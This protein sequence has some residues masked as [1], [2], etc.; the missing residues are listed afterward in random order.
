MHVEKW[1]CLFLFTQIAKNLAN[2]GGQLQINPRA[3]LR[4]Y[5]RP[6]IKTPG[7]NNRRLQTLH[8]SRNNFLCLVIVYCVRVFDRL[9]GS[10]D[11][12]FEKVCV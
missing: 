2:S 9:S 3:G 12:V 5:S 8:L 1:F 7:V 11:V 10:M 4:C 6:T